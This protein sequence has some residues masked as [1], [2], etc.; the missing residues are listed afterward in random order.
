MIKKISTVIVIIIGLCTLVGMGYKYDQRLAKAEDVR[1]LSTRLEQKIQSDR[2]SNLQER[3]WS[4]EDRYGTN[5]AI[6]PTNART[7]YRNLLQDKKE[8]QDI[9]DALKK[10]G[11]K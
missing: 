5:C 10:E 1:Q 6:M 3:I 11:G 8:A 2:L 9:L 7:E 4:Y